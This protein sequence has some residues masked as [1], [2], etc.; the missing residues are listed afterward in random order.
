MG[1][2]WVDYAVLLAYFATILFVGA[3][4]GAITAIVK[5]LVWLFSLL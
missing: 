3:L 4:V 5:G 2:G 1:L